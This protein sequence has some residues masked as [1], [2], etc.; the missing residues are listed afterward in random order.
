MTIENI[1]NDKNDLQDVL[2]KKNKIKIYQFL[3]NGAI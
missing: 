1:Q 3:L 2:K